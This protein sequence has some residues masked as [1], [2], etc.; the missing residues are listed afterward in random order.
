MKIWKSYIL[1]VIFF[2]VFLSNKKTYAVVINDKDELNRLLTSTEIRSFLDN[3]ATSIVVVGFP[4]NLNKF[5]REVIKNDDF[6]NF[7]NPFT[8]NLKLLGVNYNV[9]NMNL[10]NHIDVIKGKEQ[11][12]GIKIRI[13]NSNTFVSKAFIDKIF[14]FVSSNNSGSE[15]DPSSLLSELIQIFNNIPS[16]NGSILTLKYD[17]TLLDELKLSAMLDINSAVNFLSIHLAL[18][19]DFNY[20]IG[21]WTEYTPK[22]LSKEF[23]DLDITNNFKTGLFFT[24]KFYE[25][26]LL[27]S[28]IMM[29]DDSLDKSNIIFHNK[30]YD[31]HN[32]MLFAKWDFNVHFDNDGIYSWFINNINVS[33]TVKLTNYTFNFKNPYFNGNI[34]EHIGYLGR[35]NY[36]IVDNNFRLAFYR[37][38]NFGRRFSISVPFGFN[39]N[40]N[41]YG[42]HDNMLKN[43]SA[44]LEQTNKPFEP[45]VG[46]NF[47]IFGKSLNFEYNRNGYRLSFMSRF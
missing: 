1:F 2:M 32:F 33:N 29:A 4:L 25:S 20:S 23:N 44:E 34:H 7:V 15:G 47:G 28:N 22:A 3:V 10:I 31:T 35:H 21:G 16:I 24:Q 13:L 6:K 19:G 42:T 45:F 43:L 26:D 5:Y 39:F 9:F 41:M 11:K 38:F 27:L 36:T 8:N 18:A 37:T 12:D 14:A 30:F 17:Y 46:L 40:F